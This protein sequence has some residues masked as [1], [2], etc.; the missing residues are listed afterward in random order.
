VA[1]IISKNKTIE[2]LTGD[3]FMQCRTHP[4][5][6]ASNTCSHCASW[7]CEDCT[8]EVRGKLFCRPCLAVLAQYPEDH[9][10]EPGRHATAAYSYPRRK[11]LWGL[12]F[13]F[14]FLPGANYMYMGLMKRGLATM[15]GFFLIIFL[16][17]SSVWPFNLLLG[18]TIPVFVLTSFFDGFNVRRR[19]NAGEAVRDD[20]GDALGGIL[21]DK[22]L[23][24][25]IF[26][27]LAIIFVVSVVGIAANLLARFL[28]LLIIVLGVYVIMKRKNKPP[29][30]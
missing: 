25:I 11:I 14:S 2:T 20:I 24:T 15:S 4:E 17:A 30:R 22:R 6:H 29:S 19:I 16:L 26:V 9:S 5:R 12:L 13:V 27:A 10:P 21:S 23:R 3:D 18:L 8:V 28:P 1:Y 7:L